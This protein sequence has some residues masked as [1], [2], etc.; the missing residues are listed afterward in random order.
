MS[1]DLDLSQF[2]DTVLAQEQ[3]RIDAGEFWCTAPVAGLQFYS[4]GRRDDLIGRVIPQPGDPVALMRRPDNAKDSR[5]IEVWW[6]NHFLL[7]HIP[8]DLAWHLAPEMD[9]GKSCRAYT[10]EAGDGTSWSMRVVLVGSA[11]EP[12][13]AR[14][15]RKAV[16]NAAED[17]ALALWPS[18]PKWDEVPRR[19]WRGKTEARMPPM[20]QQ[21]DAATAWAAREKAV[22]NRGRADAL[23]AFASLPADAA[24]GA[25]MQ[26]DETM[27]GH[28]FAR[29]ADVPCWLKTKKQLREL[30][31]KPAQGCRFAWKTGGYGPYELHLLRDAV[32]LRARVQV[33][34]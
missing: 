26:P 27:R 9:T 11:T 28:S 18:E 7:G 32:P 10:Y 33:D 16:A 25:D 19:E 3:A 21:R 5:A 14:R 12:V 31:F 24:P 17:A 4:Y 8:H 1:H 34:A 29:W 30:G 6:R 23:H 13:H 15:V 2:H 20:V 22:L